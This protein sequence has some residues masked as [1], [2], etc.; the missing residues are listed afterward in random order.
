M[1]SDEVPILILNPRAQ[2]SAD[3]AQDRFES[4]LGR[5]GINAEILQRGCSEEI[6]R[7]FRAEY[8]GAGQ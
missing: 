3:D 8:D 6:E 5:I 1:P 4:L 2:E 7:A